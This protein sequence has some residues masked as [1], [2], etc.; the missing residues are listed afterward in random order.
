MKVNAR[1]N[2]RRLYVLSRL[3]NSTNGPVAEHLI[4]R[5]LYPHY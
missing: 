3:K 4:T 2:G 5:C 1:M